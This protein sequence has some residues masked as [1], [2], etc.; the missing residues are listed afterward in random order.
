MNNPCNCCTRVEF[1][2]LCENKECTLWRR[3]FI[4]KWNAMREA[5]RL[6]IEKRPRQAE[7]V[8]IGGSYYA[9]PHR[10]NSYLAKDPCEDCLCPRDLCVVPCRIKRDWKAAKEDV[11]G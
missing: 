9:L 10:V 1:P 2:R 8:C 7:G 4:Q 5:P 11:L 6:D 3:W